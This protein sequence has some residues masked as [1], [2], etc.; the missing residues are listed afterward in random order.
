MKKIKIPK[1][2]DKDYGPRPTQQTIFSAMPENEVIDK[3]KYYDLPQSEIDKYTKKNIK[4][5]TI[6]RTGKLRAF[7]V[8][9]LN[10]AREVTK[11]A[12]RGRPVGS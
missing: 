1:S 5:E 9:I 10:R 7:K 6:I 4:G 2:P 8:A 11:P 3:A 12:S